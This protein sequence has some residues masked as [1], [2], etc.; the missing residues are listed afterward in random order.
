[1]HSVRQKGISVHSQFEL[2]LEI[3]F[4]TAPLFKFSTSWERD[5]GIIGSGNFYTVSEKRNGANLL[6]LQKVTVAGLAYSFQTKPLSLTILFI[7]SDLTLIYPGL[8]V[9]P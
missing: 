8:N 1:M 2:T 9:A 4:L 5:N 6:L 3:E 7:F